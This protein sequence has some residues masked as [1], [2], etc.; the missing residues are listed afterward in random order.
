MPADDWKI[1]DIE[2]ANQ[3]LRSRLEAERSARTAQLAEQQSAGVSV[4]GGQHPNAAVHAAMGI[5]TLPHAHDFEPLGAVATH[6]LTPHGGGG[7]PWR[8]A[9][10]L[11]DAAGVTKTNIGTVFVELSAASLRVRVDMTGF[12][13]VRLCLG[14]NKIG[15]GVQEWKAQYSTDQSAWADMTPL[16]SDAGVC[17]EKAIASAYGAVPAAARADVWIRIVGRSTVAADDPIVRSAHIQYR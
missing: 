11:A 9:T 4:S 14:I 3:D 12:V 1:R 2:R 5:L 16:I 10:I 17:G 7:A 13:D 6:A 8:Q 15:T